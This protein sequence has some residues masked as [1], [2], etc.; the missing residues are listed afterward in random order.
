M[1]GTKKKSNFGKKWYSPPEGEVYKYR[2][3]SAFRT[4]ET[5]GVFNLRLT[6][7]STNLVSASKPSMVVLVPTISCYNE[8]QLPSSV[9]TLQL[10]LGS[11]SVSEE[12]IKKFIIVFFVDLPT[13]LM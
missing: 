8:L 13:N 11:S 4:I 2:V 7:F 3:Y 10:C 12:H 5:T 6:I 1:T 9:G